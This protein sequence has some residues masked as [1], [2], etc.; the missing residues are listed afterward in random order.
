MSEPLVIIG[1]SYAGL[2]TALSARDAGYDGDILLI[3]DERSL[4]YQRPPLSKGYLAGKIAASALPIRPQE[5]LD[6]HRIE[7]LA[8]TRVTAVDRA[9]RR[10]ETATGRRIRYQW[11]AFATGCRARTLSLPGADLDGVLS[12]RTLDD[13]DALRARLLAISNAVI[14]GGGFI[15][16]EVAATLASF[17]KRTTIVE[18]QDRLLARAVA[19]AL[20]D[21][22]AE[23]HRN[24]GVGIITGATV[25]RLAGDNGCVTAAELDDGRKLPA[26][27][28]VVGVGAV[29]NAE[30]AAACGLACDDGIL[31]DE[32]ARS[33]DPA[34]VAAGDCTRYRSR[35]AQ[36]MVRL[37]SV[38]NAVDQAKAAGATVAGAPRPYDAVPWFW[39]DQFDIKLQMVGFSDGH[40]RAVMRGKRE[41]GRFSIFYF[42]AGALIAIDSVNRGSD[43]MAGRQLIPAQTAITPEQAADPDFDLVTAVKALRGVATEMEAR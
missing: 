15:G 43:H 41:D 22:L 37:E 9:A 39:S 19:P 10:V 7:F 29:V 8:Q 2:H 38:Q 34:I 40:D 17:G 6:K 36:R 3:G 14:V 18:L 23:R 13:A 42:K 31:V 28:V 33:G 1:A 35:F 21:F 25:R 4:P 32:C 11:L 20:S 26:D 12:L 27:L 16:L 5:V 24:A 30:L